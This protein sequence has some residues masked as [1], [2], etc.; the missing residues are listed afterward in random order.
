MDDL[1]GRP[2]TGR[3]PDIRPYLHRVEE[4]LQ[5]LRDHGA[6]KGY[7]LDAVANLYSLFEHL[8]A[9]A[10]ELILLREVLE[11]SGR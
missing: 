8:K 3:A 1:S 2:E 5:E 7:P 4:H 9:L 6:P 11:R 10:K